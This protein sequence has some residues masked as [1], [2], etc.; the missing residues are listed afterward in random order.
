LLR[1]FGSDRLRTMVDSLGLGDDEAIEANML[2]AAIERAQRTVEGNNFKARET[3]LQFDDV[4]NVQRKVIYEE[5]NKVLDGRNFKSTIEKHISNYINLTVDQFI[6]GETYPE[7]WNIRSMIE[8]MQQ[9]FRF[10]DDA[11]TVA[12]DYYTFSYNGKTEDLTRDNLI[13]A[14]IEIANNEYNAKEAEFGSEH[15]RE[16]ERIILLRVV[17]TK[18]MDHIDDMDRLRQGIGLRAYA[19]KNPINE[20]KDEG[21][22]MYEA[23][24]QAITEEVLKVIF[25]LTLGNKVERKEVAQPT[26]TSGGSNDSASASKPVTRKAPKVGRNDLCPCGSGLKYKKCCGK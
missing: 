21:Y 17:D 14:F 19:Q 11:I 24:L 8:N 1:K 25:R 23:M 16:I 5:R 9:I 4:M 6:A 10:P 3:V 13:E 15:M 7:N 2:S 20:Y 22:I 18:W 12:D 26:A